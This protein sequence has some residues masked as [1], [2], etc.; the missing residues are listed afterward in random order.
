MPGGWTPQPSELRFGPVYV[1][2]PAAPGSR[3]RLTIP[4]RTKPVALAVTPPGN[5]ASAPLTRDEWDR[6]IAALVMH[7]TALRGALDLMPT[8]EAR[9]RL[10]LA[11]DRWHAG[12]ADPIEWVGATNPLRLG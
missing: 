3:R 1:W 11:F 10:A 8:H 2:T 4:D 5:V 9:V 7:R 6:G 12:E